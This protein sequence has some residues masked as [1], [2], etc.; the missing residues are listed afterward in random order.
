MKASDLALSR[1]RDQGYRMTPQRL[2]ILRILRESGEH[3]SP[4]EVYHQAK[5]VLPGITEATIYRTLSF[6]T[7]HGL[8]LAAHIGSGQLVY[9][10]A[11]NDH[12]HLICR[13]CGKTHEVDHAVLKPLY[14]QFEIKTGYRIDSVHQTFFGLCPDCQNK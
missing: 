13:S 8:A 10:I 14:E 3:L 2:A 9:E 4:I 1:L 12:D 6:L 11:E 5:E 7:E